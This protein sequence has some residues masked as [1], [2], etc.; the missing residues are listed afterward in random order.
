MKMEQTRK[1]TLLLMMM[2]MMMT[3]MTTTRQT[4]L[5]YWDVASFISVGACHS[6]GNCTA[7]IVMVGNPPSGNHK[8]FVS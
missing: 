4:V 7:S 8:L 2:M 5:I 1:C 6:S 3:M